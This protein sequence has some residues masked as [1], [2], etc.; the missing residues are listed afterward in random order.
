MPSALHSFWFGKTLDSSDSFCLPSYGTIF[1]IFFSVVFPPISMWIDQHQKNY[2]DITKIVLS[3]IYTAFLYFPGFIYTVQN[4]SF[5][6]ENDAMWK[7]YEQ[8]QEERDEKT[9][10]QEDRTD[11]KFTDVSEL[12]FRKASKERL[13]P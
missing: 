5:Y 4:V 10:K 12:K 3:F 7:K 13:E 8:D 9:K 11:R 6:A 2:P 1:K